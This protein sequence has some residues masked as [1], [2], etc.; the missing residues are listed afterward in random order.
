MKHYCFMDN[1]VTP[2]K[3]GL[4]AYEN[5][6]GNAFKAMRIPFGACVDFKPTTPADIENLP[7]FGEKTRT[8]IFIGYKLKSGGIFTG[9]Y[10][11]IDTEQLEQAERISD[12][13]PRR[14][15]EV[16]LRNIHGSNQ[17]K[18]KNLILTLIIF[19]TFS[20]PEL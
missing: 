16:V 15:K 3:N 5:R 8:G 17:D 12:V 19:G 1:V 14:I 6:F 4:T 13:H 2:Q 11:V 18:S 10:I 9:D 20:Q 7:A